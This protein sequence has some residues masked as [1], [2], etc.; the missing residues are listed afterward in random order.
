MSENAH[1][2]ELLDYYVKLPIPPEYAILLKGK[3]G[4]GKTW[5]I[6]NYIE[7][8]K[9][10]DLKFLYISLYG[11]SSTSDIDGI[12]FR[13]LHPFLASK[14]VALTSKIFKGLVKT[15]IKVDLDGDENDDASI[16]SEITEF[17]LSEHLND[18]SKYVI[19]F[20]DLER[21]SVNTNLVLGYMN[22]FVEHQGQKI[23]ILANEEEI[24]GFKEEDSNYHKIKE[25]V[26][27][28]TVEVVSDAKGAYSHFISG[29]GDK[30]KKAL[31][32]RTE[33]IYNIYTCAGYNNLRHLKQT[34]W[35]F[36]RICSELPV[37]SLENE[38]FV[39]HLSMVLFALSF[40]IKSGKIKA[41]KIDKYF[42]LD[43][44][45]I[46]NDKL[47]DAVKEKKDLLKKY[48]G[49]SSEN[50]L[51]SNEFWHDFFDKGYVNKKIIDS[52]LP[53]T[54]YFRDVHSENWERLWN[55][56]LLDEE[57]FNYTLKNVEDEIDQ[58]QIIHKSKIK[59][60]YGLLLQFAEIGIYR[61]TKPEIIESGKSYI[62]QVISNGNLVIE[63]NVFPDDD[64]GYGGKMYYG[65]KLDEFKELDTY[66][67]EQVK[68]WKA[69]KLPSVAYE[70]L[71]YAN[72]DVYLFARSIC[73]SNSKESIYY[74]VPLL[75]HIK[76][77]D[78][79]D[80]YWEVHP[81]Q[82]RMILSA[83]AERY[84]NERN[85]SHLDLE[86]GW[87]QSVLDIFED[88][89]KEKKGTNVSHILDMGLEKSF[90]FALK[91]LQAII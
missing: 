78:F 69:S 80:K 48:V 88:N 82:R 90:R 56:Y 50:L 11:V 79:V 59:H 24:D 46:L 75:H 49:L 35:E 60:V 6:K 76:P 70:I 30:A 37:E 19:V 83:I 41:N 40:E 32:E 17:D 44:F 12:F 45:G 43:T 68:I 55:F 71:S 63:E 77:I 54:H 25:K 20:D 23:I 72:S 14:G 62:D 10:D 47:D 36:E 53:Q 22:Q 38:E 3:W 1:V 74:R 81:N 64:D 39:N 61:K 15:T 34:V 91:N 85:Y 67:E 27:G 2:V 57:E 87:V 26:I 51:F 28:K 8:K 66:I 84:N 31:E 42:G 13:E 58:F 73:Q 18:A 5:F 65:R 52:E 7:D 16:R 29:L 89:V 86:Q 4:S 33:H 9:S 21:T